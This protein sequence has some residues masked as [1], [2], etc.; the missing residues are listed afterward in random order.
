VRSGSTVELAANSLRHKTTF[1]RRPRLARKPKWRTLTKPLG[2]TCI[3]KRRMVSLKINL[4]L[5][6]RL[7]ERPWPGRLLGSPPLG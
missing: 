6:F 7:D 2:K 3:R 5:C 4:G 1:S